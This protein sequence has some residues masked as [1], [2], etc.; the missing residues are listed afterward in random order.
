MFVNGLDTQF[1]LGSPANPIQN[2]KTTL[3]TNRKHHFGYARV[4]IQYYDPYHL[5]ENMCA[6]RY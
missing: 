5:L 6:R 2:V 4:I 1:Q 3:S